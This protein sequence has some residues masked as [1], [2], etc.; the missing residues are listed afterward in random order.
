[1]KLL[2]KAIE[3]AIVAL[4]VWDDKDAALRILRKAIAD[5]GK[6]DT[7]DNANVETVVIPKPGGKQ[8]TIGVKVTHIEKPPPEKLSFNVGVSGP[9]N[10]DRYH[11]VKEDDGSIRRVEGPPAD[12][13]D[14]APTV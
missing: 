7:Q 13:D 9:P 10:R 14:E 5:E 6:L 3:D 2:K 4:E 1:M 8:G 12:D 11:F